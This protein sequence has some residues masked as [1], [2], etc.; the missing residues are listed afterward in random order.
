[1]SGICGVIWR[2]QPGNLVRISV[3]DAK[4]RG[5]PIFTQGAQG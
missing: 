1:V 3:Q 4:F 2:D 5:I